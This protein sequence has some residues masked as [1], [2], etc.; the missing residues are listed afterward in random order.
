[1]IRLPEWPITV[2]LVRKVAGDRLLGLQFRF[3]VDNGE[4]EQQ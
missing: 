4:G 3:A 1:M 2:G